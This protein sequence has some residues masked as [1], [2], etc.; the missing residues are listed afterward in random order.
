MPAAG[1]GRGGAGAAGSGLSE[2][3]AVSAGL[4]ADRMNRT[5]SLPECLCIRQPRVV[6]Y[7]EVGDPNG[8]VVSQS[9]RG[10]GYL[11]FTYN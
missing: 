11:A 1:D 2:S 7:A 6:S 3:E 9:S 10:I 5:V 8:F 4:K